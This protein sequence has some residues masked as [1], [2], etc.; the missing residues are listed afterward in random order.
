MKSERDPI[1]S[2]STASNYRYQQGEDACKLAKRLLEAR[3]YKYD[4]VDQVWE[5]DPALVTASLNV[6]PDLIR[7]IETLQAQLENIQKKTNEQ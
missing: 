7:Q 3:I 4:A 1:V 5:N 6:M 2:E